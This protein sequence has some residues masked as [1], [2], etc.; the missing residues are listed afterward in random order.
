MSCPRSRPRSRSSARSRR[1]PRP[2]TTIP[3]STSATGQVRVAL[4]THDEGGITEKDVA[5]ANEIEAL[6]EAIT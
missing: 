4:S 5:L 3:T 2:Q 1:G 6:A